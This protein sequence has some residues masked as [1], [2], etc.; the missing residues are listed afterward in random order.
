MARINVEFRVNLPE[1][2]YDKECLTPIL[3]CIAFRTKTDDII[4]VEGRES[5]WWVE[6]GVYHGEF[7]Y[8]QCSAEGEYEHDWEP[9]SKEDYS[10]LEHSVPYE[11]HL[12]LGEVR[13]KNRIIGKNIKGNIT[14]E[15][16]IHEFH[17]EKF[18]I[19]AYNGDKVKIEIE[20][21]PDC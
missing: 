5:S 1:T 7:K 6:N 8:V 3:D 19:D 18:D 15:D 11:V 16:K 2:D 10:L 9:L 17:A 13:F 20:N 12:Y 21:E 14:F 4:T